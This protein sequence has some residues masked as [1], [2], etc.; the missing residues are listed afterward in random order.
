MRLRLF[1][2]SLL[3]LGL[4]TPPSTAWA[5]EIQISCPSGGSYTLSMPEGVASNG[6]SCAGPLVIDSRVLKIARDTFANS[7]V[8]SVEIPDSVLEIGWFAFAYAKLESVKFSKSLTEISPGAFQNNKLKRVEIPSAVKWISA[9]SFKSN[10]LE[11]ITLP[12]GLTGIDSEA[13]A[14]TRI[15]A[16]VIP[17]TVTRIGT[18]AFAE[19]QT[20]ISVDLSDNLEP[21]IL[22]ATN[23]PSIG[24][25]FDQSNN[26]T[27]IF[28]CGAAEDFLVKP[29]CE[30]ERKTLADT[31][32]KNKADE[33][34]KEAAD[35]AL[36]T[37]EFEEEQSKSIAEILYLAG[38][39][40]TPIIFKVTGAKPVCPTGS[41]QKDQLTNKSFYGITILCSSLVKPEAERLALI[42]ADKAAK[43]LKAKQEADAK[44]AADKAAAE[45]TAK[46]E[47]AAK[48]TATPKKVTI[49]CVK[50][51]VTKKVTAVKPLC[52]KGYKKK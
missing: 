10:P 28:Y 35:I 27:R 50:G 3:S 2:I 9:F 16:L 15:A 29:I 31:K 1:V 8:S 52:P 18:R 13:F 23:T 33:A 41:V 26:I 34:A 14:N 42:A 19:I 17:S 25:V 40:S 24:D 4:L 45:Q 43:E 30:G 47:A 38:M 48:A 22:I 5:E 11:I 51:K 37:K 6:N 32:A 7:Q 46:Q 39:S 21:D 44:A 49:T 20:L 36:K 12:V